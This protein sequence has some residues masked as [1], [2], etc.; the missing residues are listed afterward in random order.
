MKVQINFSDDKRPIII[1]TKTSFVKFV[2]FLFSKGVYIS[3]PTDGGNKLAINTKNI[4]YI[5]EIKE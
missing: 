1:E 3:I 5:W 4:L 2:E